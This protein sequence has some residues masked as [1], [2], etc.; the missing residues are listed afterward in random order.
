MQVRFSCI[1][2]VGVLGTGCAGTAGTAPEVA[3][4]V[5]EPLASNEPTPELAPPPPPP[6]PQRMT[7]GGFDWLKPAAWELQP[8]RVMR[9]VTL[10][11][12]RATGD[13]LDGEFLMVRAGGDLEANVARWRGQFDGDPEAEITKR[14]VAGVATS[15]VQI[16]G[17]YRERD[18]ETNTEHMRSG[19]KMVVAMVHTD[20]QP[21]FIKMWGP[22]ST[23][24]AARVGFDQI[25]DSIRLSSAALLRTERGELKLAAAGFLQKLV[26][27]ATATPRWRG[28]C[29]GSSSARCPSGAR[30]VSAAECPSYPRSR[31][32]RVASPGGC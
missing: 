31:T 30:M 8:E 24:D 32:A 3:S 18:W 20:P 15:I 2:V 7:T 23:I 5:V 12:P 1:L 17:S 29:R 13:A 16:E 27:P 14:A 28:P 19:Y 4:V 25:L 22:R 21:L 26:G 9:L 6:Q 11:V 10:R